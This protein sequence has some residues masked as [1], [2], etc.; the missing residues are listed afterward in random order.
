MQIEYYEKL[1]KALMLTVENNSSKAFQNFDNYR[2]CVE[3]CDELKNQFKWFNTQKKYAAYEEEVKAKF[4]R[5]FDVRS[6]QLKDCICMWLGWKEEELNRYLENR[7]ASIKT[8]RDIEEKSE[9]FVD[10]LISYGCIAVLGFL[11]LLAGE[12]IVKTINRSSSTG[13]AARPQPMRTIRSLH[14]ESN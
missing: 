10:R 1:Q 2:E 14:E 9:L 5:D 7:L 13:E 8:I 11:A 4:E 12:E 6:Q 3:L